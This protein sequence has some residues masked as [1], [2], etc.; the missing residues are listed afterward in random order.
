MNCYLLF[1]EGAGELETRLDPS[2][3]GKRI[4][5][6][7][8]IGDRRPLPIDAFT[9]LARFGVPRLRGSGPPEGGTPNVREDTLKTSLSVAPVLCHRWTWS[10]EMG[11]MPKQSLSVLPPFQRRMVQILGDQ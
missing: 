8:I 4:L 11:A 2:A 6:D 7:P 3:K 5:L 10:A 1:N 9:R